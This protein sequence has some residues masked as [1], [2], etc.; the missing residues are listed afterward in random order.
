MSSQL[1]VGFEYESNPYS[2]ALPD[3]IGEMST[4]LFEYLRTQTETLRAQHNLIQAG[5]ST[6]AWQLLNDFSF[7]AFYHPGVIGRFIHPDYGLIRARYCQ[8][9][10]PVSGIWSGS[11][12]GFVAGADGLK[13][14]VTADFTLSNLN[15]LVGQQA[16][17]SIPT[18]GQFGWV[19]IDGINTQSLV[20][21]GVSA[22][23]IGTRLVW[24]DT[25]KVQDESLTISTGDVLGTLVDSTGVSL[26]NP[27]VWDIPPASVR[28]HSPQR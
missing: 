26:A 22:P 25:G 28:I 18:S 13:W 6:F 10:S 23:A 1:P 27:G 17:Y 8:F 19:L 24:T 5:D 11:P 21:Y 7:T 16:G 20:Y 9:Q 4:G 14:K 15:L 2:P 12:V 3:N